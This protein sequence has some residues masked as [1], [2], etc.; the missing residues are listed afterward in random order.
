[1]I[2][3]FTKISILFVLLLVNL[4]VNAQ[5]SQLGMDIDGE[6]NGDWFGNSVSL[7]SDG[8]IVAIG[9]HFNDDAGSAAGHVRVFSFDETDWI[10][11]GEDID[12]EDET[13]LSGYSVSL[14][15][16]GTIL[17]I[18]A[19]QN[20]SSGQYHG[21]VR[22]YNFN[23]FSWNQMGNDIDGLGPGEERSGNAVSLSSNG[24]T[25]AIGTNKLKVRIFN[26]NGANW[27]QQ[28]E[29]IEVSDYESLFGRKI[30]LSSDGLTVAIGAS[31]W[32]E[33][34]SP[35]RGYVKVFAFNDTSW[36]QKGE[37]IE[38]EATFDHS[39][40]SVSLGSNGSALAIGAYKNSGS[41]PGAG[42][43]RVYSYNGSTWVQQGQDIDGEAGMDYS[44]SA[45]SL[46]SDGLT[47]AIGAFQN[48]GTAS[49]AG[50]AR[51]YSF[52][53]LEW[54]Q[55]GQDIDGEVE[56]DK[57]G[58][59]ISLS[60]NGAVVAVAAPLNHGSGFNTGHVRIYSL[61]EVTSIASQEFFSVI[62][63]YPI[64]ANEYITIEFGNRQVSNITIL[65]T[66]GQE[67]LVIN[68]VT[69]SSLDISLAALSNGVYFVKI[70][71]GNLSEMIKLI[72][73]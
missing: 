9:A 57:S 33:C 36:V 23:G 60:S 15:S 31:E 67:I 61:A 40:I 3:L 62:S 10:Q 58:Y 28:G 20:S 47:V 14:S 17:A 68:D 12:G 19:P 54:V 71:N 2:K 16:D 22:V 5:F 51:I 73:R 64:P 18:G 46:S 48:D 42:H 72:K 13:D 65:N 21:H 66:I 25:V 55:Q 53:G 34:A 35:C 56:G 38:G 37:V 70:T 41:A 27:V 24:Q 49:N 1:M 7:S 69:S 4:N 50:H 45:V 30:S 59:A 29:D 44:G 52:E 43:V 11:L 39:G 63:L 8:S 32:Q 6:A 26:F